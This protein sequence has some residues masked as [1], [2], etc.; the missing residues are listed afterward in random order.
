MDWYNRTYV[1][2]HTQFPRPDPMHEIANI[3]ELTNWIPP[4]QPLVRPLLSG[5]VGS[6]GSKCPVYCCGSEIPPTTTV[7]SLNSTDD[8][9]ETFLKQLLDGDNSS[10]KPFHEVQIQLVDMNIFLDAKYCVGTSCNP[11]KG[12]YNLYIPMS[13]YLPSIPLHVKFTA[14]SDMQIDSC[15]Q[16]AKLEPKSCRVGTDKEIGMVPSIHKVNDNIFELSAGKF[17]QSAY[18]FRVGHTSDACSMPDE[19]Q[20]RSFDEYNLIFYRKCV[21]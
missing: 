6:M 9:T 19:Q 7:P 1:Y 5:C 8:E 12:R 15:G 20:G 16:Y 21:L 3:V 17:R 11:R 13:A 14:D 4:T 10:P 18:R 2:A